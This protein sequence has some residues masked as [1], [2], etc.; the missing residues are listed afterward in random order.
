MDA[1]LKFRYLRNIETSFRM[2]RVV[3]LITVVLSLLFAAGIAYWAFSTVQ[4][5]RH[6]IY[7]LDGGKSIMLALSQDMNVNR[8]AEARD[9]VK[10]FHRLFFNQDPDERSIARNMEEA[11]YYGD[12]SI[13]RLYKDMQEK[14]FFSQL[15][16]GNTIEKV[17]VDTIAVDM[18]QSPYHVRCAGRQLLVRSS[19]ITTRR[20][21]T[22][23]YLID[24]QRTDA[25]P[26]GFV[27][28]NFKVLD[29]HDIETVS[30]ESQVAR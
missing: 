25:N 6:K 16:Q 10:T 17:L 20:L 22:E 1:N 21:L 14:G 30:R 7:V 9:H 5:S 24:T 4:A 23:C 3:A 11:S 28:E 12:R 26:H 13:T 19:T 2:V 8:E 15:I 18:R 29:N 27:I